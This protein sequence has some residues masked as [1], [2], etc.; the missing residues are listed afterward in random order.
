MLCVNLL[1]WLHMYILTLQHACIALQTAVRRQWGSGQRQQADWSAASWLSACCRTFT[2]PCSCGTSAAGAAWTSSCSLCWY[3]APAD[4]YCCCRVKLVP[5]SE[6]PV[7]VSPRW[8]WGGRHKGEGVRVTRVASLASQ[9]VTGQLVTGQI[10]RH[11]QTSWVGQ[12]R[13]QYQPS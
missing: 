12:D 5:G 7:L 11:W 1:Q 4:W 13:T 3:C 2:D 10:V 9:L 8:W 6:R